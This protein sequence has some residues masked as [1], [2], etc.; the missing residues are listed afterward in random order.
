MPWHKARTKQD[1][2]AATNYFDNVEPCGHNPKHPAQVAQAVVWKKCK[3]IT[4]R[5][6][7]TY[8]DICGNFISEWCKRNNKG[9]DGQATKNKLIGE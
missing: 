2:Q 9:T 3:I 7:R 4:Q 5:G 1:R 8:V 6:R